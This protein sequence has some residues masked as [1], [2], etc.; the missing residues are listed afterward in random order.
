MKVIKDFFC[1]QTK[2]AYKK[3]D[4]YDG[5]RTDLV[6]NVDYTKKRTPKT[7]NKNG[8]PKTKNK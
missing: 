2:I 6:D 7:K 5:K 1:I 3:G 8:A 4:T